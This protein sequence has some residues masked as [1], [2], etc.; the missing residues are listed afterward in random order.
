M[1]RIPVAS[2]TSTPGRPSANRR[3]QSITSRVT[4]PSPVAR[5]G[6]IAGIHVRVAAVRGPSAIGW[7]SSARAAWSRLGHAAARGSCLMR[8][9]GCHTSFL[10]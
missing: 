4:K 7:N 1:S 9:V 3:Y 2:T 6:T 5:H 8:S 10:P